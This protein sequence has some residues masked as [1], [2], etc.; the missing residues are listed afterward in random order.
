MSQEFKEVRIRRNLRVGGENTKLEIHSSKEG[1]GLWLSRNNLPDT[2][3]FGVYIDKNSVA[4]MLWPKRDYLKVKA[5]RFP[6]SISTDGLQFPH[7]D[8]SMTHIPLDKLS[9]LI[10]GLG[11]GE[12][13]KPSTVSDNDVSTTE[14]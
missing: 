9:E 5:T 2:D 11:V 8:G 7:P 13:I 3:L 14:A 1:T 12:L 4:V 6:I 10:K